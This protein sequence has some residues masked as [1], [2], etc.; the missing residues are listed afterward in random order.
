MI[1]AKTDEKMGTQYARPQM[2]EIE[3]PAGIPTE[4][5][6]KKATCEPVMVHQQ[7]TNAH[8]MN[9]KLRT[10]NTTTPSARASHRRVRRTTSNCVRK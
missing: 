2:K 7:A 10:N 9:T 1:V 6:K 5:L 4:T 3:H 8:H